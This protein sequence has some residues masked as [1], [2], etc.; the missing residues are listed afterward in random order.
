M[1][2]LVHLR[3]QVESVG[4][5]PVVYPSHPIPSLGCFVKLDDDRSSKCDKV[6]IKMIS[7][8][9]ATLERAENEIRRRKKEEKELQPKTKRQKIARKT[10]KPIPGLPYNVK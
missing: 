8:A 9:Q 1:L 5:M 10:I 4:I 7:P 6:T 3:D 2:N